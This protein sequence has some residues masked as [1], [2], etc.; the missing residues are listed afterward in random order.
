MWRYPYVLPTIRSGVA[1]LP[2]IKSAL[3]N[4]PP[5][6]IERDG[7]LGRMQRLG[8]CVKT[9]VF[10]SPAYSGVQTFPEWLAHFENHTAP[11]IRWAKDNGLELIA[12]GDE[13]CREQ[14]ARD[15]LDNI[16]WMPDA[17]KHTASYIAALG[18]CHVLDVVDESDTKLPIHWKPLRLTVPWRAG[19]GPPEAFPSLGGPS[20]LEQFQ[21][22]RLA[23]RE[24]PWWSMRNIRQ[25]VRAI[26]RACDRV[27]AGWPL[28][29]LVCTIAKKEEIN[30]LG[31]S[32][33]SFQGISPGDIMAQSYAAVA[34]GSS[35]LEYFGYDWHQWIEQ[36]DNRGAGMTLHT[37]I[38]YGSGLWNDF[39]ETQ[40]SLRDRHEALQGD[41]FIPIEH[42]PWL[43]CRRGK[44]KWVIN[45]SR[46]SL[47]APRGSD[48]VPP[49]G[50]WFF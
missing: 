3:F 22:A 18:N 17:V 19:G 7:I 1:T 31:V 33:V 6:E 28:S 25:R 13:F 4:L 32:S 15:A 30:S 2:R 40:Y 27:P 49:S 47:L 21:Y 50:V 10:N 8:L 20:S 16:S 37:G 11:R 46:Y 42:G 38:R 26:G 36:R 43:C 48:I 23:A 39:E 35:I 44:L 12:D 5:S 34:W 9:Q 14:P 45:L 41:V 29:C 24:W